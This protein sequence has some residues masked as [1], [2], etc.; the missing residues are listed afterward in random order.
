MNFKTKNMSLASISSTPPQSMEQGHPKKICAEQ[1]KTLERAHVISN[2]H[3]S[4][5]IKTGKQID[6][7]SSYST[8]AT[9]DYRKQDLVGTVSLQVWA[10]IPIFKLNFWVVSD[11]PADSARKC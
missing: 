4:P 10:R 11:D 6:V 5:R 7:L 3:P 1:S 9:S 2:P 8:T